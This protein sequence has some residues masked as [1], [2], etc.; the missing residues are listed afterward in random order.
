MTFNAGEILRIPIQAGYKLGTQGQAV[1]PGLFVGNEF[2]YG[3]GLLFTLLR[4][5]IMVS[6]E[7]FGRTAANSTVQFWTREETPVEVLAGFKYLHRNGFV[8]GAMGSAGVTPG[9][10]APDWRFGGMIGFT[11]PEKAD[12]P[13]RRWRWHPE[14]PRRLPERAG[15]LRRVHGCRRL[16]RSR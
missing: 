3:G 11:M 16:S 12:R 4:E 15:R 10:G 8:V 9:Y 5:T 13:R 7:V 14:R 1:T 2:T 6:A